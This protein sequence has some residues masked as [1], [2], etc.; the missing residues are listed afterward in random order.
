MLCQ[1]NAKTMYLKT[2]NP[3]LIFFRIFYYKILEMKFFSSLMLKNFSSHF[4]WKLSWTPFHK[5]MISII[6]MNMNKTKLSATKGL[7]IMHCRLWNMVHR[8][9][10]N[11]LAK[12]IPSFL[13]IPRNSQ[14]FPTMQI[15]LHQISLEFLRIFGNGKLGLTLGLEFL[16]IPRNSKFYNFRSLRIVENF[17]E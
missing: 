15:S 12:W 14:K 17:W 3:R 13:G 1:Q 5:L 10:L 16:G 8:S 9:N 4:T 2:L 6:S 7:T 11:T